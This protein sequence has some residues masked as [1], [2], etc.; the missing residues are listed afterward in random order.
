MAERAGLFDATDQ[1]NY[2][3][4]SEETFMW[5]LWVE[6]ETRRRSG[7]PSSS[8]LSTPQEYRLTVIRVACQIFCHDLGRCLFMKR[9]PSLSPL[10]FHVGL[11]S[12]QSTWKARTASEC[13]RRL[14]TLPGQMRLST[15]TRQIRTASTL[16]N[17]PLFEAS[18]LGMFIILIGTLD[19]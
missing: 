8:E 17:Q 12:Y 6:Q 16:N 1:I 2:Q 14:Q 9:S 19:S 5:S 3:L 18:T 11:P 13:L 4:V 7:P 10:T 15:A